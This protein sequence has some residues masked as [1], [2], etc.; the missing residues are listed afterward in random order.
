MG[1]GQF[2]T[3]V[4][5]ASVQHAKGHIAFTFHTLPKFYIKWEQ[6]LLEW[7]SCYK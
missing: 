1:E 3:T 2:D 5:N 7:K 6:F 4:L